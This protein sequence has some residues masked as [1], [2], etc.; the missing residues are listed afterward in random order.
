MLKSMDLN[1]APGKDD[2]TSITLLKVHNPL[3]TFQTAIY[4]KSLTD[5]HFP[6]Q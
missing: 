2:V 6:E 3:L 5:A 1:K 4:N